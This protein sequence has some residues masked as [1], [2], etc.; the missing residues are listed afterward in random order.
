VLYQ[1]IVI[2]LNPSYPIY[3]GAGIYSD[4]TRLS[5]FIHGHQV[6]IISQENI[7]C[8]YLAPLQSALKNYQCDTHFIRTG[9]QYKTLAEWQQILDAMLLRQHE[10]ST[11]LIA[12]GGGMVGDMTGFAAACY[13]R[14]VNYIQIPTTLIAQVDAAIGGKTAL[15][16]PAGKNMLGSF[17][18]PRCV[19]IDCDLLKTLAQR[20][21]IAG[22]AEVIKYALICDKDFFLWLENNMQNLLARDKSALLHAIQTSVSIKAR[23][24][25]QDEKE[26]GLRSLLNFG[27]TFGHAMEAANDYQ[28]LLH[29]EAVAVGMWLACKLSVALDYLPVADFKRILRL[30]KMLGME[31]YDFI[32]P[33]AAELIRLMQYDKKV[34]AGKINFIVLKELGWAVKVCAISE[35]LLFDCLAAPLLA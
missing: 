33:E 5:D 31:K 14:G 7:S 25:T 24:I 35:T 1:K 21:Y 15:N 19:I 22:L 11:T 8:H 4:S 3:I 9:E 2:H 27:H 13:Q 34:L 18:Q 16:H 17:Y 6:F 23:I 29:G 28:N 26:T 32:F 12:L 10:R 30:L 20:E